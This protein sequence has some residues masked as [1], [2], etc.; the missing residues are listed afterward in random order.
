MK[1]DKYIPGAGYKAG[2][3]DRMNGIPNKSE[4]QPKVSDL[5]WGEYYTGWLDAHLGVL[6]TARTEARAEWHKSPV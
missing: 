3:A 6:E 1:P 2:Y 5:Y 4:S